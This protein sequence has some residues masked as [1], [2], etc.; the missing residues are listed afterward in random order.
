VARAVTAGSKTSY[1]AASRILG[2]VSQN[3]VYDL[4]RGESQAPGE[5]LR[6]RTAYCTGF[7]RLTVALLEEIGIEAREVPG[8]VL[9]E[10][11]GALPEFHRWIE[12]RYPDVG[13]VF[14][15]PLATHNY[16]PATYVP[17][18]DGRVAPH[19]MDGSIVVQ[20]DDKILTIDIYP[21]VHPDV[22]ARK[23]RE[24]QHAGAL[25]ISTGG[26][27]GKVRLEGAGRRRTLPMDGAAVTFT[28]VEPGRY[29]LLLRLADG[30]D[31]GGY[32]DFE[33]RERQRVDLLEILDRPP[34]TADVG[35]RR[36]R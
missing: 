21:G 22:R 27:A 6:R 29:H 17:L 25:L 31:V 16:V 18:A 5:V 20:R 1:E 8:L 10:T 11:V 19:L 9:P 3:L 35:R 30:L 23:N 15:D 14:S 32:V 28:G 24:R 33:D 13:W 7:A 12:I 26:R 4:D 34:R 36:V 2:W